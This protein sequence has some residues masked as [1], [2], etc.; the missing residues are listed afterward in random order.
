[1][2]VLRY[3][4]AEAFFASRSR[5]AQSNIVSKAPPTRGLNAPPCAS[6]A[7][8]NLIGGVLLCPVESIKSE[9]G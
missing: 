2:W 1:M 4:D 5:Q 6:A 3:T 7:T 9:I 8:A